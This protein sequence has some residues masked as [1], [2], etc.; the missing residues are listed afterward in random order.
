MPGIGPKRRDALLAHFSSVDQL[1]NADVDELASI[2]GVGAAAA[3]A[4]KQFFDDERTRD[5]AVEGVAT[6][7]V[8]A[9]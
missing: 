4:V 6:S 3:A 9:D 8:A 1:K 5:T 2:S 7:D